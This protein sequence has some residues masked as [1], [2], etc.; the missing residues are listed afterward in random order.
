MFDLVGVDVVDVDADTFAWSV[1]R[2]LGLKAEF[3]LEVGEVGEF[4]FP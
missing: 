2:C 1:V 3:Y 4:C